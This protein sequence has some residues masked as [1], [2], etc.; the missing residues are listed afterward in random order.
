MN[1]RQLKRA[2]I[3]EIYTLQTKISLGNKLKELFETEI[4]KPENE[5]RKAHLERG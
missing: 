4:A 1:M 3:D 2:S 5:T